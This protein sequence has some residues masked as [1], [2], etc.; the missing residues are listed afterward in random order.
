MPYKGR[1]KRKMRVRLFFVLMLYIKFQV[2]S[3]SASLVLQPTKSVMDRWTDGQAQTNMPPQLLRSWGHNYKKRKK[4]DAYW[5]TV[6]QLTIFLKTI[7]IQTLHATLRTHNRDTALERSVIDY[8][9]ALKCLTGPKPPA[10]TIVQPNQTI[11]TNSTDHHKTYNI[12]FTFFSIFY[13]IKHKMKQS[14]QR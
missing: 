5:A 3:P 4:Q 2:P 1:P 13:Y 9:M 6:I 14:G 10:S 7:Y 11:T 12:Y 8:W